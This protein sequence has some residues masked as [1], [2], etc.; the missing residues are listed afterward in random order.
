MKSNTVNPYWERITDTAEL[1][2][3]K[4]IR[5]YG[6]GVEA[7]AADIVARLNYLEEELIDALM[8]IEWAKDYIAHIGE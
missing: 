3:D 4:G 2:R 8:F 5:D 1:Q 7:N 6:Q